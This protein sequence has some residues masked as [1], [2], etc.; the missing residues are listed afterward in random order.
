[1]VSSTKNLQQQQQQQQHEQQSSSLAEETGEVPH[2]HELF[3]PLLTFIPTKSPVFSRPWV[4]LTSSFVE[5]NFIELFISFML[6]I[7]LGRYVETIWGSKQFGKFIMVNVLVSN[8]TI[9]FY[10]YLKSFFFDLT[11]DNLPPVVLS[12]MSINIGLII[13]IKQRIPNHY[14]IFFKGNLR[15][16]VTYLP[17]ITIFSTWLLSLL[18]EEFHILF[19]MS[20]V[21][22]IVSWIYLRFFKKGTNERQSYLLPFALAHKKKHKFKPVMNVDTSNFPVDNDSI[23][24]DRSEQFA[25]YTFFPYP[26]SIPVKFLANA[27]F[28]FSVKYKLLNPHDFTAEDEDDEEDEQFED[29]EKLKNNLFGVSPLKGAGEISTIPNSIWDWLIP[30]NKESNNIKTSMDRRRKLA[31]K[32]LE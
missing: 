23:G 9:Y 31:L 32:E 3:V 15:V 26:L 27:I 2:P 22:S 18:S 25:L 4:L 30:K 19:V 6:I 13:A 29:V 21:G 14:L 1:M 17:L 8:L 5:E 20:I 11:S 10:Y 28:Q 7:F 16:K 12:S 24:G